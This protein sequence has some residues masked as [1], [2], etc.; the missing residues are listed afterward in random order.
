M[1]ILAYYYFNL[2]D[3][4]EAVPKNNTKDMDDVAPQADSAMSADSARKSGMESRAPES[5]APESSARKIGVVLLNMGGP[6]DIHS[7]E[8]FLK[9]IFSDPL[10]LRIKNNFMRKMV[11]NMIIAKR[12]EYVK[13]N[14]LKIG[15]SSP[16]IKHTFNLTTTLNSLDSSKVYTYAM[17]YAPPFSIDVLQDLQAQGVN[18]LVLF[19]MYPQFS[20]ATIQSSL[21]DTH[22]ALK[23]LAYKPRV[24]VIEH[25]STHTP[26]YE[27]VVDSIERTLGGENAEDFVL[28][29]S[30]HSLPQSVVDKGDPYVS[31]CEEGKQIITQILQER[32]IKFSDIKLAYQ[33][34]V[35]PMR[36]LSPFTSD[37]IAKHAHKKI[38]IYPLAFTIDNS[39]TDYELSIEYRELAERLGVEDYRVC[40]CMNDAHEF[41]KM[42]ISLVE[43]KLAQIDSIVESALESMDSARK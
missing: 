5:N 16:I 30:A 38:L 29:L 35:G 25:F 34:K 42:I 33:S 1:L 26:F 21:I 40:P 22:N 36:W 27:L 31:H 17:R 37:T 11:G 9:N 19:S 2:I 10:T 28:I 32:G 12:L 13:Q 23:S 24:S 8:A 6:T 39:E 4:R 3:K 18:D 41:A 7:I 43:D 20:S 14:Y 15:G